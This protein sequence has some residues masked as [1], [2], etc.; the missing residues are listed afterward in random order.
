[1]S[2]SADRSKTGPLGSAEEPV[3]SSEEEDE[4]ESDEED[5]REETPDL[6]RNSSL[7]MYVT[8]VV[9]C[10]YRLLTGLQVHWGKLSGAGH[11]TAA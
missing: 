5:M 8:L 4:D 9:S 10:V 1:M 7:G 2:R 11:F 3:P 6:Y